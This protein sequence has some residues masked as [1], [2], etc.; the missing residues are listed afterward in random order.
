MKVGI[1]IWSMALVVMSWCSGAWA[2]GAGPEVTADQA[3]ATLQQGNLRFVAGK[4]E[5]S[6]QDFDRRN[7]TASKG[8]HPFATILSCSDSR[9]PPEILFDQG[10]GDVFIVRVAGNVANVDEAASIEY[11][12]DHLNTPLLVVLGHTNCGA[13]T[14]VVEGAEAHGNVPAL[15]KSIVPAVARTKAKDPKA[16][17][18]HLLNECIKANVWQAIEDLFRTSAIVTAK[19]KDGKIKVVGALYDITTGRVSWLGPHAEQ[20]KLTAAY[21]WGRSGAH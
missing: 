11:A 13:I 4:Q 15:L 7:M 2:A 6:R 10:I 21:P 9:V 17:G 19:T 5:H 18:E 1:F 8:Q 3:L 20:D 14:A 12:V 16:S